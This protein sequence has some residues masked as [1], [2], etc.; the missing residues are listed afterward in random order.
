[1][2]LAIT[3]LVAI[4]FASIIGTVLQQNQPYSDYLLKFG[5]F[6]FEVFKALGLFQVYSAIWFLII[7]GFL[8]LST[9]VCI[10][11]N[12]PR[13]FREMQDFR[14]EVKEK[15]LRN[16][17]HHNEWEVAAPIEECLS[18][19]QELLAHHGF[20]LR[21]KAGDNY[22]LLSA[23]KGAGSRWG[24][25]L[26]HIAI[27]LICI[28]GLMDGNV[29]LKIAES[30]GEIKVEKRNI[31]A[32]EVPDISRLASS[33]LSYRGNVSIPEGGGA[34]VVFLGYKD[35]YLVQQLPFTIEV[36][37]FRI[38]HY[39]SGQPKSFESDLVIVDDELEAP[40]RET[41]SVNHPLTYK[42]VSIYQASFGDGGSKIELKGWSLAGAQKEPV[43]I[44]GII[45]QSQKIQTSI[46]E[47]DL[48]LND[49]RLFN[50][51]P[52]PEEG[53]KFHN[54][55]SSIQFKLRAATGEAKEYLNYM[56]PISTDG[57][58]YF[59]SGVR[60]SPAEPFQYLYLPADSSASIHR[61]MTFYNRLKDSK[62]LH[63]LALK[64]A[65]ATTDSGAVPEGGQEEIANMMS[66]LVRIYVQGG[67]DAVIGAIESRIPEEKREEIAG[68]YVKILRHLLG[69]VYL[70][71]LKEEGQ[72]IEKG[73]SEFDSQFFEDAGAAIGAIERYGSPFYFQLVNYEHIQ[74]TGLQLT[75]SP[76][77]NL[78]YP[79]CFMLALGVFLMF[80]MPQRRL[81]VWLRKKDGSVQVIL[82]GN[83]VRNEMDF[84]N[85]YQEIH[86]KLDEVF[87]PHT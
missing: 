53:R 39:E 18:V 69:T 68:I 35:G 2:N 19:S 40:L 42:G 65:S 7:L 44:K 13:M 29:L 30:L 10:Y 31:L 64:A 16:H 26:T 81:W 23:I 79:G 6:W 33:N 46:G 75:R 20:R 74:A 52:S 49:F 54:I 37:D 4:S 73:M 82:S 50:I 21:E 22:Q 61:F 77:K 71:L 70:D 66:M 8:V 28:G 85:E 25:L 67:M 11:R 63:Q 51:Q 72:S 43:A 87:S 57:R 76:G 12:M 59:M 5:P 45:N 47:M 60:S 15:S 83:A 17:K 58:L 36:E 38:E 80:Y 34:N 78:V 62:G 27:V 32:N 24:Y 14:L 9:S 48:E 86:E 55:G 56:S 84:A 3:L 41:I 1:M